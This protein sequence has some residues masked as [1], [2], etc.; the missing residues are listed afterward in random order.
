MGEAESV[1]LI[2]KFEYADDAALVDENAPLASTRATALAT[3][4]SMT[5]AAMLISIKKSKAMHVNRSMRVDATTEANVAT[6]GLSHKCDSCGREFTKQRGLRL[7][8]A[9]WCG[10]G[11]TQRSRLGT[12]TDKAVKKAKRRVAEAALDRVYVRNEALDN[13]L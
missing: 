4:G 1:I 3:P 6:L 8:M 5:V 10:G 11:R 2:S 9:R 7:H 13:V 12:M